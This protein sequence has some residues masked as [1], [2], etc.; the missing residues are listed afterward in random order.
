MKKLRQTIVVSIALL[1]SY[2]Q[3]AGYDRTNPDEVKMCE[4]IKLTQLQVRMESDQGKI[5]A[6]NT[7]L[8]RDMAKVPQ[9]ASMANKI[10]RLTDGTSKSVTA[11]V[12]YLIN[13]EYLCGDDISEASMIAVSPIIGKACNKVPEDKQPACVRD[14]I[15]RAKKK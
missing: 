10:A 11:G 8:Y 7:T 14:F 3:A 13:E 1:S 15:A 9:F 5:S 12:G 4:E 2:A 6:F